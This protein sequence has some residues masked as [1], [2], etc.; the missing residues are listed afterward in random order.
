[1]SKRVVISIMAVALVL[2]MGSVALADD[3]GA[4]AASMLLE[5][6]LVWVMLLTGHYRERPGI[7]K[8]VVRL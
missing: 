1:M 5:L 4:K 8:Q 7:P 2:F 3:G 6:V